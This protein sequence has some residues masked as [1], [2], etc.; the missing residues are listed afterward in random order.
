LTKNVDLDDLDDGN[1]DFH[2][3]FDSVFFVLSEAENSFCGI[4]PTAVK[5]C[6]SKGLVE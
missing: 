5:P 2:A 6:Y 4:Q 1:N 3:F